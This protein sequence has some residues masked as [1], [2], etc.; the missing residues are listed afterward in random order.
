MAEK[1]KICFHDLELPELEDWIQTSGQ[2]RYRAKQIYTW[3]HQ[4]LVTDFAQMSNL[5]L[6]LRGEL[7]EKAELIAP[8]VV[9]R[10][11][12]SDGT[13]KFLLRFHD[14]D[15]IETVLMHYRYGYTVCVSTQVGCAMGC[16][17]C[18]STQAG[19]Q[20]N[21]SAGEIASEVYAVQRALW[22]T[23]PSSR[24]S[25]VVLMGMGEPLQNYDNVLKF[26][27]ILSGV[28]GLNLSMRNISLSTCG[29]VPQIDRLAKENLSL[30]LSVSLHA[31]CNSVRSQLMP[32][33]N[34]YPLQQLMPA[35]RRYQKATGRR[36]SFEYALI[37]GVNDSPHM[38]LLLADL[39]RGVGSHI[40]LI[41]INSVD[42]ST[43][44]ASDAA[45]IR[46]FQTRLQELG[47]NA[48]IR[49]RLGDDI[50][51]A[52]GQLRQKT[53]NAYKPSRSLITQTSERNETQ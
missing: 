22:R 29:I 31:P 46:R 39:V 45:S 27:R 18:A 30:T 21:L 14:S 51:A 35:C 25:H 52:C 33:N 3:I 36:I 16:R 11:Q 44:K 2:P 15:C 48:T 43:Y 32:I 26:L 20:R 28:H 4:K 10:Q 50:D 5:P 41:P 17:F 49:R 13:V 42:G 19:F 9:R 53:E 38:A 8:V 7:A 40:N 24:I 37:R 23:D 47:V 6:Q 34:V 1:R 12:S